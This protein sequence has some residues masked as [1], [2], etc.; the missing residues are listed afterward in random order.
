MDWTK[1][2]RDAIEAR[3]ESLLLSAAAG[4]GKTA[5]LVERVSAL[6]REGSDLSRMLIVTFTEA[7][8]AEM[9]ERIAKS[10]GPSALRHS[11]ISTFHSFA[12]NIIRRY[13]Y[14]SGIN[15]NL[16]VCD[17]YRQSIL[18]NEALD[19]MFEELFESQDTDF[20]DFLN[21]YCSSKDNTAAREMLLDFNTFLQS[22]PE[23]ASFAQSIADGSVFDTDKYMSFAA[24]HA[25]EAVAK[26]IDLLEGAREYLLFP[27]DPS[28]SSMPKLAGKVAVDIAALDSIIASFDA[29]RAEEAF[30]L[31]NQL[32]MQRMSPAKAEKPSWNLVKNNVN[33]LREAAKAGLKNISRFGAGL[34]EKELIKEKEMLR[35]PLSQLVRLER[36]FS[37]RYSEKKRKAGV[38][39]FSDIEHFALD[40]LKS[41]EVRE[42]LRN[43][44][45][46]IFIDE[47]QDSNIVQDTLI[48]SFARED[49]LF[50]VGDVK[51]S[52]YKFRLAEPELFISKYEAFGS[53]KLKNARVIDLNSN[54]RSKKPLIDTVNRVFAG[55]MSKET[56][57]IV[58]DDAA[59]LVEGR[60]YTGK[61][62]YEP[63]LYIVA[64][65][66][67]EGETVDETIEE[68]KGG[69]LE[70]LQAAKLIKEYHG[71][72]IYDS[73]KEKE[74]PLEYRDMVILMPAVKTHGETFYKALE[75]ADIPVFLERGQ[76]YFDTPEIQIFLNLLKIIDNFK[77]DVPL[78]SVMH[79]PSF[80][81]SAGELADI[82]IFANESGISRRTPYSEVLKYYAA[83]G[84]DDKL[85]EKSESFL[86]K[87]EVFRKKA[88]CLPLA[89]FCWELL[90]ES[91]AADFS[92]ALPAGIQRYANLRALIARAEEYES[93]STGGLYGFINY[94]EIISSKKQA[95]PTGQVSILGEGADTV[96]IMTI[97]K[98]KGLEFP[99][100]LLTGLGNRKRQSGG[101]A[102][103]LHKDFGASIKL[104][105][106]K[107][108]V[109]YNPISKKL[110]A[111]KK[112]NEEY[113]E[114]VRVLYVAMTRAKDVLLMTGAH[115][116]P[117]SL[118]STDKSLQRAVASNAPN[119]ISMILPYMPVESVEAVPMSQHRS[120]GEKS[121][122][123]EILKLLDSGFAQ[124][125]SELPVSRE[126]LRKRLLHDYS[127]SEERLKKRKYSVSELAELLKEKPE[128]KLKK[129]PEKDLK[130]DSDDKE[131]GSRRCYGGKTV[132]LFAGGVTGLDA[133]AKGTAYHKVMAYIPFDA[134]E[135]SAEDIRRLIANL[136]ERNLIS[137]AEAEAVEVERI[138]AFFESEIGKRAVSA[139]E[140][141]KE[142]S[143]VMK[144]SF[145]GREVYVQG[146]IDCYFREGSEYVLLDYK[147]DYVNIK[148]PAA[149]I[150]RLKENY[151]PQLKLYKEALF[152]ITGTRVSEALLYLFGINDTV[153][154]C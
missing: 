70:A 150:E 92:R 79:F 19:D 38:M 122:S 83:N 123:G 132:P 115:K 95:V 94:I 26:A 24:G 35:K 72:I 21:C 114:K 85:K 25:R 96:R 91:G 117:Y 87:I 7:A 149:D 57:G 36:D 144:T 93:R 99:F 82:R 77:Q 152:K 89:D 138:A 47:Y 9:K 13:Y 106:S 67:E 45:D 52:I 59:A 135:K 98:S 116:D 22:L 20:R 145:E 34:T 141:Y 68:L 62:L 10:S 55:I 63:K 74:R 84:S 1:E 136:R 4:S 40:I 90:S 32:S 143:F 64:S 78:I 140:L 14:V 129:E 43:S 137:E 29:G 112:E 60:P 56:S 48:S 100:V 153:K 30:E 147:S 101:R 105:N 12:M 88:A 31:L 33:V 139:R 128:E 15:P 73:K 154:L 146:T 119:Y 107:K 11:N 102:L 111:V 113:A 61:R 44:F 42:E 18:K 80:G 142:A 54:F 50:F 46:Y 133:A 41:E 124:E 130:E 8:A 76:G 148:S 6:L 108:S 53:G 5:V 110:I 69:E 151:L 127:P 121:S 118:L 71:S 125:I 131:Q 109:Y 16:S 17:E 81:F 2:Q 120:G 23:P 3:N 37:S 86:E 65:K 27:R 134:G 104:V 39:D 58:Y 126:E 51:Q 75:S 97:H 28:A 49:N 103:E 66:A